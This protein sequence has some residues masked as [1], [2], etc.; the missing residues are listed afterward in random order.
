MP[1]NN[2]FR[3]QTYR[4]SST[5]HGAY[6][7][8]TP[9]SVFSSGPLA[10]DSKDFSL[11]LNQQIKTAGKKFQN[12]SLR[13]IYL[14]HGT[15]VGNDALGFFDTFSRFSEEISIRMRSMASHVFYGMLNENARYKKP[16]ANQLN[17][18]LHPTATHQTIQI[19]FFN[20]SS[21]NNHIGRANA[22]V[23]LLGDLAR[24][25]EQGVDHVL[26]WG[27]SHAGNVFALLTNLIAAS[28]PTRDR[29]FSATEK[30]AQ[31]SSENKAAWKYACETLKHRNHPVFKAKRDIVTFGTPISYG[32]DTAGYDRLLHFVN[33]RPSLN[34]EEFLAT[35]PPDWKQVLAGEGGDF[36]Q[37]VGIAGTDFPPLKLLQKSYLADQDL[38]QYFQREMPKMQLFERLK[39]GQRVAE[40]GLTLL[41]DYAATIKNLRLEKYL[42]EAKEATTVRGKIKRSL[43]SAG[44]N[45]NLMTEQL[46]GHTL[47]THVEWLPF[48]L[49]EV[50]N[51]F[52]TA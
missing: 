42:Q 12:S 32:W 7:L 30:Y 11:E 9:D 43:S 22:A 40:D 15:F 45:I 10:G 37:Q 26:L 34:T 13:K 52:Y 35:F 6:H 46:L 51:R 33:H 23:H 19:D 41:V 21:Q 38:Q 16:Y 29:F 47:Y 25:A 5:P 28:A 31:G 48:H 18:W 17:T 20:W 39:F 27:H 1:A 2:Q 50:A 14:V 49:V 24:D 44:K 4:K 8:Y 36:V 3:Y